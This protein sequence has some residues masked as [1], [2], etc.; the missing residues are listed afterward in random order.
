M[1][2]LVVAKPGGQPLAPEKAQEAYKAAHAYGNKYLED[3][4]YDCLYAFFGGGGFAITNAESA[5]EVY[6]IL[7]QYPMYPNF[8]WKVT[9]LL[10]WNKTF[11]SVFNTFQ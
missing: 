7:I 1:K 8:E 2:F 3:G 4:T 9:P 5:D 10:D 11:E 6:R